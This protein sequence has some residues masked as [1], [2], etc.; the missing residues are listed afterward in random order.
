V[1]VGLVSVVEKHDGCCS[2]SNDSRPEAKSYLVPAKIS[3]ILCWMNEMYIIWPYK[4]A[5]YSRVLGN[6]HLGVSKPGHQP[7]GTSLLLLFF[8]LCIQDTNITC[9]I[10]SCFL[11]CVCGLRSL[12]C[13][14]WKHSAQTFASSMHCANI[15]VSKTR[16]L[17]PTASSHE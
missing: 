12:L 17:D 3:R 13:A 4:S 15:H 7:D 2:N 8:I 9:Q 14:C 1:V 5:K 6:T 10:E 16:D 11:Q